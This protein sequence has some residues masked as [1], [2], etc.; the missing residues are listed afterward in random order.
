MLATVIVT[1]ISDLE[2]LLRG[3][4]SPEELAVYQEWWTLPG[5]RA[6]RLLRASPDPRKRQEPVLGG[7]RQEKEQE[8]RGGRPVG[9]LQASRWPWAHRPPRSPLQG[10]APVGSWAQRQLQRAG[11]ASQ[12]EERGVGQAVHIFPLTHPVLF[13]HLY[14]GPHNPTSLPP[15]QPEG[16]APKQSSPRDALKGGPGS[17]TACVP[18]GWPHT[19][20][21]TIG[22]Q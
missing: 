1:S 20:W 8:K 17:H 4:R 19:A 12:R 21:Y 22:A 10:Q 16:P 7:G 3:C 6:C 9:L 13:T 5:R 2:T 18:G 15:P 14:S 11:D